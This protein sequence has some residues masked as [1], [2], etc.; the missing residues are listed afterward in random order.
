MAGALLS[1]E[2]DPERLSPHLWILVKPFPFFLGFLLRLEPLGDMNVLDA[3]LL[4]DDPPSAFAH[5]SFTTCA[6]LMTGDF[7]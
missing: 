5:V 2:T 3:A 4:V 6:D 1:G 7:S